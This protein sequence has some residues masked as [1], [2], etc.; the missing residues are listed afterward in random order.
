MKVLEYIKANPD[1]TRNMIAA[2]L[3]ENKEVVSSALYSLHIGRYVTRY[4][5]QHKS[6]M[7]MQLFAYL[8]KAEK[9][10]PKKRKSNG[11]A[12]ITV[13]K[14]DTSVQ[15]LIAV[16]GAKETVVLTLQQVRALVAQFKQLGV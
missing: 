4:V 7:G 3:K 12:T 13:V 16:N 9:V 14:P 8:F 11:S 10:K 1:S 15:V 5:S 2:G 6:E